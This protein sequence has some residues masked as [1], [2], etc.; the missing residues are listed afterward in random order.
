[1]QPYPQAPQPHVSQLDPARER[2]DVGLDDERA[3]TD[4]ALR[5]SEVQAGPVMPEIAAHPFTQERAETDARLHSERVKTDAMVDDVTIHLF[6]EQAAHARSRSAVDRRDQLLTLVSHELRGPLTAI[7]LNADMLLDVS[8]C[9]RRPIETR[10]I[11]QDVKA[12]CGQ[13]GRLVADLL[14]L[15]SMD[16]G[17]LKVTLS[18][19]DP[20]AALRDAVLANT[21]MIQMA[22]LSVQVEC[23]AEP[24]SAAIDQPRLIQVFTNLLANAVKF[25]CPGGVIVVSLIRR[26][27]EIEFGVA[28]SGC[29]I[30]PEF[31]TR[32]FDRFWQV[33]GTDRRGVGLGL[34]ICKAIVEAHGGRIWVTSTPGAGSQFHF[35]VPALAA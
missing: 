6:D 27:A 2:T 3:K 29:G 8:L 30:P 24:L 18:N 25:S 28:D 13:M 1:M 26:D 19:G 5:A 17:R 14:D 31:Q 34:Y 16:A 4:A 10:Q 9:A 22:S 23:P 12:A 21:P 7:A 35:T 11:V 32:V 20:A 15:A 33:G